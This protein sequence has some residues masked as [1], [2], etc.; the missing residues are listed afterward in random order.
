M[1]EQHA[2][3]AADLKQ[4]QATEQHQAK[5]SFDYQEHCITELQQQI[6]QLKLEH[7]EHLNKHVTEKE[8][9]LTEA[10]VTKDAALK[11]QHACCLF[12]C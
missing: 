8:L 5:Q 7:Q 12:G 9:L 4:K 1:Q 6:S 3:E 2:R 10:N 11:V